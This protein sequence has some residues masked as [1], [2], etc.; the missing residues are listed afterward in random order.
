MANLI[1]KTTRLTG[2]KV[3]KNPREE[4]ITCYKNTL[5]IL[6]EMP[7]TAAYKRYTMATVNQRLTIVQNENDPS[8]IE[9]NIKCGQCEELLVQAKNELSLARRFLLEKPWEPMTKQPPA[10]QWKWPV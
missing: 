2:L 8:H 6:N 1:K 10:N 3:L 7:D 9:Q 5:K 4:L